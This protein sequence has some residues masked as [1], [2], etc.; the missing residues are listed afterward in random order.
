MLR[1][2]F[3][4]AL[5]R[6][7]IAPA[8]IAAMPS[9]ARASVSGRAAYLVLRCCCLITVLLLATSECCSEHPPS[10]PQRRTFLVESSWYTVHNIRNMHRHGANVGHALTETLS[11]C[12]WN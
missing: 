11:F 5:G 3:T 4:M 1:L 12:C 9:A 2:S 10:N 7:A 6:S 8:L